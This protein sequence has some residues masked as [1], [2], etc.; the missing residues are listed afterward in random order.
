MNDNL[1]QRLLAR[2]RGRAAPIPIARE[3]DLVAY[4]ERIAVEQSV[5]AERIKVHDLPAIFHYW[6]N[7]HLRPRLESFGFSNPDEFFVRY[8]K[9]A[10]QGRQQPARFASLG[11]GNCDLEVRLACA[12]KQA[13]LQDFLIECIDINTAMLERGSALAREHGVSALIV[14]TIGDFNSWRPTH[15][16]AAVIANHSLHHVLQLEHLFGAIRDAIDSDGLFLAADMIGRNGHQRWPE[17]LDIVR[18][19]WRELPTG[20]RYNQQLRR[21]EDEFLDWDCSGKSFEGIRAQDILPLLPEYFHFELFIGFGNII[22]PFVDR[23]FGHHFDAQ[24]DWDRDFIDR[25]HARDDAEILAGRIKPT[26]MF[27][28]LR[29]KPVAQIACWQHLTPEFC[30]RP[31]S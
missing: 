3:V 28:V 13:G 8:L 23:S 4:Q 30:V 16:Y 26:Q 29:K 25:V 21:Q 1:L 9:Q 24:A 7:K 11:S 27:A 20:Y 22:Y 5:F 6:S 18:E 15:R 14:P 12:L 31:T 19:F 17:A 10:A 2:I